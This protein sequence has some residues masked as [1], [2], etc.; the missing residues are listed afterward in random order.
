MREDV[1]AAAPRRG[2]A[3]EAGARTA[4]RR[5]AAEGKDA[6]RPGRG[7]GP[8]EEEGAAPSPPAGAGRAPLGAGAPELSA[9]LRALPL[10]IDAARVREGAPLSLSLGRSLDV[11]LRA[12]AGGVELVLR[13]EPRLARAAAAEL[14]A[15]VAALRARGVAVARAEI[16][17]RR[18]AGSARP[19]GPTA[20]TSPRP[21]A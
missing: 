2:D 1:A 13:P 21:S 12:T 4:T 6:G 14:P 10:A 3:R 20:L 9:A 16:R 19:G 5:A 17:A 15:L 8:R 7:A 11:D 18:D